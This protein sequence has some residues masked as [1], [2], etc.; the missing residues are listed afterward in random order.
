M[1]RRRCVSHGA[2]FARSDPRINGLD[3]VA[4]IERGASRPDPACPR[5]AAANGAQK[6]K[7]KTVGPDQNI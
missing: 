7:S 2:W 3:A 5:H 6:K 4:P 1:L